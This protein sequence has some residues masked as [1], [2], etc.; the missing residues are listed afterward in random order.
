MRIFNVWR[1]KIKHPQS[2]QTL[3]KKTTTNKQ[4]KMKNKNNERAPQNIKLTCLKMSK[5]IFNNKNVRT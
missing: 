2:F 5:S 1:E 3:T 4:N